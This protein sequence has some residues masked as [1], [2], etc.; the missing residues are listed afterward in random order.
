M[1]ILSKCY[2]IKIDLDLPLY[3]E[4]IF[5]AYK[6]RMLIACDVAENAHDYTSIVLMDNGIVTNAIDVKRKREEDILKSV[7]LIK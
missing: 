7:R 5:D 6:K 4:D 3:G 2:I 1:N